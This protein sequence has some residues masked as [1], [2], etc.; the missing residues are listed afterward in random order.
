MAETGTIVG[1]RKVDYDQRGNRIIEHVV[2]FTGAGTY[3]ITKANLGLAQV[4]EIW[5]QLESDA[6][7][8]DLTTNDATTTVLTAGGAWTTAKIRFVGKGK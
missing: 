4:S 7:E 3:T 5:V 6:A 8:I 1:V 2:T